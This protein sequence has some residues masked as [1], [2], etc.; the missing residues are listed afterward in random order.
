MSQGTA[1]RRPG[2]PAGTR[3]AGTYAT[4]AS[5]LAVLCAVGGAAV[6]AVAASPMGVGV[7]ARLLRLLGA[8]EIVAAVGLILLRRRLTIRPIYY[9]LGAR[10]AITAVLA[11]YAAAPAGVA[12]I[13]VRCI[14]VAAFS[15]C[16]V[17]RHHTR[18]ITAV[19]L[20]GY[21]AGAAVN[22]PGHPLM[23]WSVVA[24]ATITA[25]E[26]F[27]HIIEQ[28]RRLAGRDPLTGL[29]NRSTFHEVA[30]RQISLAERNDAPLSLLLLDLDDFKTVN[31]TLGHLA[32]DALLVALARVWQTQ[33][34][35]S[36]LLARL[37]GDEFAA[38][39]PATN[40]QQADA[41][42]DRLRRAHPAPWSAGIATWTPGAHIDDMLA[43]ADRQLYQAKPG[44]YQDKPGPARQTA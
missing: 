44:P 22:H 30:A 4:A 1:K 3:P 37:G 26:A 29:A 6:V 2:V 40:R 35:P 12:L 32:G 27:G 20:A 42:A 28:L 15:A 8:G 14:S 41:V 36:D 21:G 38:L 11:T 43:A 34:R 10:I 24:V 33:L 17:P 39:L 23:L 7:P 9:C 25:E 18:W 19:T 13:G 31:D 16:F 5:V